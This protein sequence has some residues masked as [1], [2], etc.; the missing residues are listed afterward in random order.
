MCESNFMDLLGLAAV[1]VA[2]G[3]FLRLTK[4]V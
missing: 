1:L 2:I 4:D 3:I